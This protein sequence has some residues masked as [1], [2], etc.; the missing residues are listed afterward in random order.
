M[1]NICVYMFNTH[2]CT[3]V[4]ICI[5]VCVTYSYMSV[6]M[7]LKSLVEASEHV[8]YDKSS[9]LQKQ[10][11]LITAIFPAWYYVFYVKS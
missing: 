7:C 9:S 10:Y 4:H 8:R 2:I 1:K 3:Y 6:C 11:I 5:C